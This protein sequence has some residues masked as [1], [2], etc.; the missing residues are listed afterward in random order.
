MAG[1]GFPLGLGVPNKAIRA[2]VEHIIRDGDFTG[3]ITS[4]GAVVT[5]DFQAIGVSNRAEIGRKL[6]RGIGAVEQKIARCR[7]D[8]NVLNALTLEILHQADVARHTWHVAT[9]LVGGLAHNVNP[10]P[11]AEVRRVDAAIAV[12]AAERSRHAEPQPDGSPEKR[13]AQAQCFASNHVAVIAAKIAA[14]AQHAIAICPIY[15]SR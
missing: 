7:L 6:G 13:E 12:L 8:Y 1:A 3:N 9:E 4:G 10:L 5:E 15:L 2:A 11:L 14:F